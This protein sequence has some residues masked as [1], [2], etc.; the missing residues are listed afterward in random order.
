MWSSP[1]TRRLCLLL[2]SVVPLVTTLSSCDYSTTVVDCILGAH[3][4]AGR[5]DICVPDPVPPS[6]RA[7]LLAAA[8]TAAEENH[9]TVTKAVAVEANGQNAAHYTT[10]ATVTGDGFVW[11][12]Q[13]AG[14]F[15]CGSACFGS[16]SRAS[17]RGTVLTMLIDTT[18]Y[19]VSGLT[20]TTRWLDLSHL[21]IV[22][23]LQR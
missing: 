8:R 4:P 13:V 1:V 3:H 11:V 2:A 14:R 21:G 18:T 5:E 10:G 23:V 7:T 20:L 15:Q 12:V 9:G 22:V 19:E 16:P 17:P 6:T